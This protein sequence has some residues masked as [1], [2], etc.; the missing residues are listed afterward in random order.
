MYSS[1]TGGRELVFVF[2]V[3]VE[4]EDG[5]GVPVRI[6]VAVPDCVALLRPEKVGEWRFRRGKGSLR[7]QNL[8]L[9]TA[10]REWALSMFSV[11]RAMGM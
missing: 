11:V 7:N 6:G 2:A 4:F 5:D 1:A 10:S 8:V 3:E 9:R